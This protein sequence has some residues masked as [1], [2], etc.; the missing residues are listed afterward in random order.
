MHQHEDKKES[1]TLNAHEG[2]VK[3]SVKR[4]VMTGIKPQH[5]IGTRIMLYSDGNPMQIKVTDHDKLKQLLT[6]TEQHT[7]QG[8]LGARVM[9]RF[10][11]WRRKVI[12]A[13]AYVQ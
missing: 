7:S 10:D 2:A 8:S 5:A 13:L 4:A 6:G 9:A 12:Q 3:S 1:Y 11:P